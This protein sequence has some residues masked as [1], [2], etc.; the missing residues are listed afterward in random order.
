VNVAE[1]LEAD[2]EAYRDESEWKACAPAVVCVC[3]W[4]GV[5]NPL[6]TGWTAQ[7]CSAP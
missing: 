2:P 4:G 5:M 6:L 7:T 3:V 1:A